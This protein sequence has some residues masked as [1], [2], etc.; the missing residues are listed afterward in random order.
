[1]GLDGW[2]VTDCT[3]TMFAAGYTPASPTVLFRVFTLPPMAPPT[4]RHDGWGAGSLEI[5]PTTA[6]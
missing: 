3:V 4:R 6:C 2:Q 5:T 1:M